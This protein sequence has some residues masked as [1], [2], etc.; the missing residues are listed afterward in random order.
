[1]HLLI[2][3]SIALACLTPLSNWFI[4]AVREIAFTSFVFLIALSKIPIK[5]SSTYLLRLGYVWQVSLLNPCRTKEPRERYHQLCSQTPILCD[6]I[7]DS[8]S[9]HFFLSTDAACYLS[10]SMLA[11]Q[12]YFH[13]ECAVRVSPDK[14]QIMHL[15][16]SITATT[17]PARIWIRPAFNSKH[18]NSPKKSSSSSFHSVFITQRKLT[19][20]SYATYS[21]SISTIP[22]TWGMFTKQ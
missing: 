1:M 2:K 8:L 17:S 11:S 14:C 9:G 6:Y 21:S 22:S 18:T 5:S 7:W 4:S 15:Q 3:R 10:R 20:S 12:V 16:Y 13:M 19:N